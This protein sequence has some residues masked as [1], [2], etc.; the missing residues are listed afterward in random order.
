MAM[1]EEVWSG[2]APFSEPM[3]WDLRF[4]EGSR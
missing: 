3:L 4:V 1:L 2:Q